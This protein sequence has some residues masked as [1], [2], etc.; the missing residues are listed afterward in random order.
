MQREVV[1]ARHGVTFVMVRRL[2]L[3][4]GMVG[5]AGLGEGHWTIQMHHTPFFACFHSHM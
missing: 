5:G 2:G 1:D 3:G 4:E